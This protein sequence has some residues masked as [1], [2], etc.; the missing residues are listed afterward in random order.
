VAEAAAGAEALSKQLSAQPQA[1]HSLL[2][3]LTPLPAAPPLVGPGSARLLRASLADLSAFCNEAAACTARAESGDDGGCERLLADGVA[4]VLAVGLGVHRASAAAQERGLAAMATLAAD[5]R[6]EALLCGAGGVEAACAALRLHAGHAGVSASAAALLTCLAVDGVAAECCLASGA[7]ELLLAALAAHGAASAALAEH[8]SAALAALAAAPCRP[9]RA[10]LLASEPGCVAALVALLRTQRHGPRVA[11]QAVGALMNLAGDEAGEA[12]VVEAGGLDGVLCALRA[13]GAQDEALAAA[14]CRCLA[15]LTL[16]H[17]SAERGVAAGVPAAVTACAAL[18]V[19]RSSEVAQQACRV[20]SHCA[21]GA[22][23]A[24]KARMVSLGAAEA[25][26]ATLSAWPDDGAVCEAACSLL[27]SLAE[28]GGAAAALADSR[29][30]L[31]ACLGR[32]ARHAGA[33]AAASRAMGGL[34]ACGAAAAR[35]LAQA[36]GVEALMAVA[37]THSRAVRV[38]SA[39]LDALASLCCSEAEVGR[40][41]GATGGLQL[42]TSC[43]AA[44]GAAPQPAQSALRL[45]AACLRAAPELAPRA[46]QAGAA[47]AAVE[48]LRRHGAQS[49]VTA[50]AAGGTLEPLCAAGGEGLKRC[51]DAGAAAAV[52]DQLWSPFPAEQAAVADWSAAQTACVSALALLAAAPASEAG[53][54]APRGGAEACVALLSRCGGSDA[55][56]LPPDLAAAGCACIA[57]VARLP[58]CSPVALRAGAIEAVVALLRLHTG[59]AAVQEKGSSA[60]WLLAFETANPVQA[61]ERTAA[62]PGGL[63]TLWRAFRMHALQM[64]PAEHVAVAAASA[65]R[66]A[67]IA[68][69]AVAR[70][71]DARVLQAG[72]TGT[73]ADWIQALLAVAKEDLARLGLHQRSFTGLDLLQ[74]AAVQQ[75]GGML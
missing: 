62:T 50:A 30:A 75:G 43:L 64:T 60:L 71:V 47:E 70:S 58:R 6:C 4:R 20:L 21:S 2:P 10:R 52:I 45:L 69:R 49:A 26:A 37:R 38:Q 54:L 16:S 24:S 5:E 27:A 36:G 39:S 7:V 63:P 3:S 1:L 74:R 19:R 23:A 31:V 35:A 67:A 73:L 55:A 51:L 12:A 41:C 59:N 57:E 56:Q 48:A 46:L 33:C 68:V 28:G 42:A 13:G 66:G 14:A 53:L 25:A 72:L 32:Q 40:R 11:A 22:T 17:A 65:Q 29:H 15:N 9:V 8:A 18:H 34:A 61:W 44:H